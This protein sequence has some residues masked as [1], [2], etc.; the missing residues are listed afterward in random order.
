MLTRF[1]C[2]RTAPFAPCVNEQGQRILYPGYR[3]TSL[4][5]RLIL[6]VG[7]GLMAFSNPERGGE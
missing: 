2:T 3:S 4:S 6:T 7:S 1:Y 5:Q